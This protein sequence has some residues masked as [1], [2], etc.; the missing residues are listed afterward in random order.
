MPLYVQ[1]LKQMIDMQEM[2]KYRKRFDLINGQSVC[3]SHLMNFHKQSDLLYK[4]PL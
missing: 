4:L 1:I 3:D 2:L